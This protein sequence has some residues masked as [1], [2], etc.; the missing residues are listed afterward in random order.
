MLMAMVAVVIVGVGG[1]LI[2]DSEGLIALACTS[3]LF[4]LIAALRFDYLHP[5]VAFLVPWTVILSFSV[6][7]ISKYSHPLQTQII[8][9][10]LAAVAVWMVVTVGAEINFGANHERDALIRG[11]NSETPIPR[12]RLAVSGAFLILY[13]LALFNVAHAGYLPLLSLL[14][15]G[16][17]GYMKFGIPSFYGAYLALANALACLA[18]YLYFRLRDRLYSILFLSVL[19][20]HVLFMTRQNVVTLLVQA[21][22]IRSFVYK[23]FSKITLLI[24]F[25]AFLSLF[26]LLG[27]LRSGNI[28]HII[29]VR[30]RYAWIPT[31]FIWLYAY[32]YFNVLNLSNMITQSGAPFYD[33]SMWRHLLPSVLRPQ[34][35]HASY[36]Q[37]ASMNVTSY[38]YP[39]YFD[40]GSAGVK[41]WT[42]IWAIVTAYFYRRAVKRGR[43]DDIAIYACLFF[44]ALLSFFVD[45]WFY[46]PVIFQVVFFAIFQRILFRSPR[47]QLNESGNLSYG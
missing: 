6:V 39:I 43:F 10:I 40:V 21:V 15:T 24:S 12:I 33:G 47:G 30:E 32:S 42:L 9:F 1:T 36:L 3:S 31:A 17:S 13:L 27:T 35:V 34:Y 4:L 26:S 37:L 16:N 5:T 46:L 8:L 23:R 22:V 38:M 14:T 41:L 2:H 11:N 25:L 19:L 7:P 18:L 28:V 44:C 29:G 20:L 45:F